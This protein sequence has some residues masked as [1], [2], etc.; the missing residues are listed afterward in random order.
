MTI[1]KYP[2][3]YGI[4]TIVVPKYSR[5]L[6]VG[7]QGNQAFVWIELGDSHERNYHINLKAYHTGD[8]ISDLSEEYMG[9]SITDN[10]VLHVYRH[11]ED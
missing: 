11:F 7:H 10:Y 2:I 8:D 5:V 4:N 3:V 9:S 1:H 6:C